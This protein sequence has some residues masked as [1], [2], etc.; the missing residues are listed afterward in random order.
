M[1]PAAT[2]ALGVLAGFILFLAAA[3]TGVIAVNGADNPGLTPIS[4]AAGAGSTGEGYA[5]DGKAPSV[6][7][8]DLN[9]DGAVSH[10]EAA[11]YPDILS[12][13][14]RA[15]RNKDGKLTPGEFDRLDRARLPKPIS[16]DAI[17]RSVRRDAATVSKGG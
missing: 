17:K 3:V 2:T 6:R 10:A 14:D 13:F 12:R 4:A 11:G 5:V 1:G 16:P 9:G 15:D 7:A 8:L